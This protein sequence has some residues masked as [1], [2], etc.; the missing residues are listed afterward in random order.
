[1]RLNPVLENLKPYHAGPS[2][3]DIRRR[4]NL[5]QVSRLSANESPWGPFP[6]VIEAMKGALDG[7]QPLSRRR[8]RR[9]ARPACGQTAGGSRPADLRQRLLRA[10]DAARGGFS[11]PGTALWCCPILRS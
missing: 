1:M 6:E 11:R 5:E 7:P 10:S 2:L 4:Y 9:V 8:V 3:D